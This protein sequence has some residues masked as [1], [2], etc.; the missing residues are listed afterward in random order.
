MD[1]IHSFWFL[2]L[3]KSIVRKFCDATKQVNKAIVLDNSPGYV[4]IGRS[5]REW[6]TS[7]QKKNSKFVLVS[8]LDEQDVDSTIMSA[9][10]IAQM[11]NDG[12]NAARYIKIVIILFYRLGN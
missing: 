3:L 7:D 9:A 5:V 10:E 12:D 6:L 1:D 8:S 4:G 11:M 2:D